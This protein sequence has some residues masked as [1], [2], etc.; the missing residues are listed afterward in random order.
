MCM[1][2]IICSNH[3]APSDREQ[4][5]LAATGTSEARAG[6]LGRRA[7]ALCVPLGEQGYRQDC[8][9]FYRHSSGSVEASG[10]EENSGKR[11]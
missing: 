4:L 5:E 3:L 6:L 11:E 1:T 7:V 2:T 8:L 9:G 10:R